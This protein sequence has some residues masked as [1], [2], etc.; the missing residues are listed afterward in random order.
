MKAI[1]KKK[2]PRLLPR[3]IRARYEFALEHQYW[4]KADWRRVVWSDETKVN[5]L[6]PDGRNWVWK[7]R[8]GAITEQHVEGTTK[9]GGGSIMVWGCMTSQGVGYACR[10][11]SRM[12]SALYTRILD[13]ELLSTL[14][15]YGLKDEDVIFQQDNA[16]VHTAQIVNQ[17]FKDHTIATLQWPAQSP[18]LNPIEH[19]WQHLKKRLAQYE[20]EPS[21]ILELWRRIEMEWNSIPQKTCLNLI[22]SMPKRIAE[23]IKAKGGYTKY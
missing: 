22:D 9:F 7:K 8:G 10:I 5:R 18:D 20:N 6:G 14:A 13:D 4:T 1:T 12:D 15:D 16:S 2:R 3:H 19:L 11:G 23:V 21:G 17:W